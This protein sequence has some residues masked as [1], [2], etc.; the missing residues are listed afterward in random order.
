MLRWLTVPF[1]R[2]I[3]LL[4]GFYFKHGVTSVKVYVSL[5]QDQPRL[6]LFSKKTKGSQDDRWNWYAPTQEI[7]HSL[8][9][10]KTTG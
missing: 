4:P 7:S 5:R 10:D 2:L 1:E 9:P 6:Y 3:F 8:K